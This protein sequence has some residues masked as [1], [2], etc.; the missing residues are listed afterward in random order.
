MRTTRLS[1]PADSL[2]PDAEWGPSSQD[3]RHRLNADAEHRAAAGDSRQHRAARRSLRR[4]YTI[5]TGRD[6]NGDG[7][8]NDRPAGVGRN[9]E[10][11]AAALR[12]E[13]ALHPRV[14]VRR[15][16]R[17]GRRPR[18]GGPGALVG[19]APDGAAAR[20]RCPAAV[21]SVAAAGPAVAT[22]QRFTLE[23]YV[24]GFN[25]LNRTNF[26]NFSG[27]LQSPFFGRPTSAAQA[28][29]VE[30]GMQFRF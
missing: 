8:S 18:G 27:N 4:P 30:V 21:R 11:G 29:R 3:V 22:N 17:R 15:L 13:R 26:V 2:N 25:V 5:T 1:L 16:A 12:H 28:R 20:D 6:D 23:F 10:R 19:A 14:R 7:V 24:Q 9:S